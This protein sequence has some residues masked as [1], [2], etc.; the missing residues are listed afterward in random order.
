M[1]FIDS[2]R[3]GVFP[4]KPLEK[5]NIPVLIW[6]PSDVNPSGQ[7]PLPTI[8]AKE[9]KIYRQIGI[10]RFLPSYL[11]KIES[12][13]FQDIRLST[14]QETFPIIFFNHGYEGYMA[15]NTIQVEMLASNGY[16]VVSIGHPYEAGVVSY[17]DGTL[18]KFDEIISMEED[19]N[20]ISSKEFKQILKLLE[21][22]NLSIE[23]IKDL[24]YNLHPETRIHEHLNMWA[25]DNTFIADRMAELQKGIISSIFKGKLDLESGIGVFGHSF[26]GATA[27]QLCFQDKRFICGIN[28]DGG[29]Y[30]GLL[31]NDYHLDTPFM[32]LLAQRGW[33]SNKYTH[34]TNSKDAYLLKIEGTK[35]YDF[36]DISYLLTSPV[37][38][39]FPV[40]G[41]INSARMADILNYYV[42]AF[43]KKYL[44]GVESISLSDPPF[45]EIEGQYRLV[46]D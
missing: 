1:N 40:F 4:S 26:G 12:N 37:Y 9:L 45:T 20:Q 5:R 23:Q 43:F 17:P 11:S 18:I 29:P 3:I 22:E 44:L 27:A 35:H 10:Y 38:K 8:S 19:A 42:D 28:L 30:G 36:A 31:S 34:L 21:N 33:H 25:A 6:Y 15:Q 7:P 24:T 14:K 41:R 13:S 32:H 39:L 16:I 2:S 46:K